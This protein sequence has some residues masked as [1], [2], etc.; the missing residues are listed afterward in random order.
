MDSLGHVVNPVLL[1][2]LSFDY[3]RAFVPVTQLTRLARKQ[4]RRPLRIC[5][6]MNCTT[7]S[8]VMQN[9]DLRMQLQAAR[10]WMWSRVS[11]CGLEWMSHARSAG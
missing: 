4:H 8:A 7:V 9:Q 3:A 11:C 1:R 5:T 2:N 6:Q 10:A